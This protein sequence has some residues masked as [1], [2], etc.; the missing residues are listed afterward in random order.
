MQWSEVNKI[1]VNKKKSGIF[2]I[3]QDMRTPMPKM[4][5]VAGI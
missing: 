5:H 3:R 4:T 1:D 2:A